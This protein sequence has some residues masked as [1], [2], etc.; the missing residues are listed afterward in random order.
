MFL[1]VARDFQ[2]KSQPL[3]EWLDVSERKMTGLDSMA[4]D[5]TQIES[6]MGDQYELTADINNHKADLDDI[7]VI[8][9]ELSKHCQEEDVTK[10]HDKMKDYKERFDRLANQSSDRL[11]QL[12]SALPVAQRFHDS[13]DQLV[14]RMQQLEGELRGK[15]AQGME[16]EQQAQVSGIVCILAKSRGTNRVY[17]RALSMFNIFLSVCWRLLR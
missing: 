15:E 12:E 5:T 13:R 16:G 4:A 1:Q 17:A 2:D 14:E 6:Q 10:L 11:E 9:H 8:G 3:S 7:I